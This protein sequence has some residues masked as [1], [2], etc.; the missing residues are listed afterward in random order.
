MSTFIR[1]QDDLALSLRQLR[2]VKGQ[3]FWDE[4][5]T[6]SPGVCFK[7]MSQCN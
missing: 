6:Q 1:C 2:G 5:A 7:L 3:A 4:L